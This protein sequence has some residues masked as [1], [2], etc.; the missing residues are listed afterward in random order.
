MMRGALCR[1]PACGKGSIYDRYLKVTERCGACGEELHH[2]RADD[3]P[4]Y[5]TMTIIGHIV[6]PLVLVVERVWGPPLTI[7]FILWTALTLGL[8]FALMPSVKGA[9]VGL[10]WALR[11][12]GFGGSSGDEQP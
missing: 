11:M 6:V 1:C 8:S 10:Q 12:H 4:P 7:H 2:H 5:F 3:A 9:I